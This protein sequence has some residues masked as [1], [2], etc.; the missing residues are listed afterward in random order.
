MC[1][2][3]GCISNTILGIPNSSRWT[4]NSSLSYVTRYR[5]MRFLRQGI[6]VIARLVNQTQ[7]FY[8]GTLDSLEIQSPPPLL[9]MCIDLFASRCLWA[10]S[11]LQ[12][13]SKVDWLSRSHTLLRSKSCALW[14]LRDKA[15][16]GWLVAMA[17]H[18]SFSCGAPKIIV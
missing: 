12:Q 16:F 11:G 1:S 8:P 7:K 10:K 3:Q 9:D 4:M 17:A 2:Q 18:V 6:L 14:D 15:T 5:Q 13:R